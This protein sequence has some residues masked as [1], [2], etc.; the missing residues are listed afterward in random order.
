MRTIDVTDNIIIQEL[1]ETALKEPVLLQNQNRNFRVIISIEAIPSPLHQNTNTSALADKPSFFDL[2]TQ[3]NLI[4]V[5]SDLPSDL[6]TNKKYFSGF[7]E[8]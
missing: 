3:H 8:N 5:A 4:G 7:G 6:S 2:A 1:I